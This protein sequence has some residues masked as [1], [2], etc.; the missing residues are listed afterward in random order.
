MQVSAVSNHIGYLGTTNFSVEVY[1]FDSYTSH[2]CKTITFIF[3]AEK[4]K[5]Y[6]QL[7]I[8]TSIKIRVRCIKIKIID[9]SRCEQ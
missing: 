2:N 6:L 9:I 8:G 7:Y 4:N 5:P 3:L 1:N